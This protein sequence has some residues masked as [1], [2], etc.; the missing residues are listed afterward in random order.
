MNT[1]IVFDLDKNEETIYCLPP[2]EAL[3]S[4]YIIKTKRTSSLT[5]K[6]LRTKINKMVQDKG[7]YFAIDT[8]GS[9]INKKG[10]TCKKKS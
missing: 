7:K 4:A 8:L 10:V 1:S 2:I 5:D 6:S 3:I 9:W